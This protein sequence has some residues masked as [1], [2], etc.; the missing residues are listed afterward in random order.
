[1]KKAN[2]IVEPNGVTKICNCGNSLFYLTR[3]TRKRNFSADKSEWEQTRYYI[4]T[5]T[6]CGIRKDEHI[7]D[8]HKVRLVK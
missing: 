8:W 5:C 1:M 7:Q 6:E 3:G 4:I 2:L